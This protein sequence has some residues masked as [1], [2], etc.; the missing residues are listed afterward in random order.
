MIFHLLFFAKA[1]QAI[2]L[3]NIFTPYMSQCLSVILRKTKVSNEV[4]PQNYK[5]NITAAPY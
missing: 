5:K 4:R 3:G 2:Y 1:K